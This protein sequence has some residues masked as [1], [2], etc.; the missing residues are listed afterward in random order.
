MTATPTPAAPAPFT[1]V[2][3]A[4]Q[5]Y[6]PLG[7]LR[8]NPTINILTT[9]TTTSILE[10]YESYMHLSEL[11]NQ[12]NADCEATLDKLVSEDDEDEE[13]SDDTI[14]DMTE[15]D[16]ET[17]ATFADIFDADRHPFLAGLAKH[18]EG[19]SSV[20]VYIRMIHEGA[21]SVVAPD[22]F[23]E[24]RKAHLELMDIS[25]KA[26]TATKVLEAAEVFLTMTK[27]DAAAQAAGT[28]A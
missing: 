25:V 16:S 20:S 28:E 2:L 26:Q 8:L 13:D 11:A 12:L 19:Y 24:L 23:D 10:A 1:I 17:A 9:A 7:E 4:R 3:I 18:P 21:I 5:S 27:D 15:D 6:N 14:V 22:T